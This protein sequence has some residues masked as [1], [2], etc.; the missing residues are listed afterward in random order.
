[1]RE[2]MVMS[3][4]VVWDSR[5]FT[6]VFLNGCAYV[7]LFPVIGSVFRQIV[8]D[9]ARMVL[10]M[11]LAL[12]RERVRADRHFV[13]SVFWGL[14]WHGE[15]FLVGE[16]CASGEGR[17]LGDLPVWLLRWLG[18]V[19]DLRQS[20]GVGMHGWVLGLGVVGGEGPLWL[21]FNSEICVG[22]IIGGVNWFLRFVF[23]VAYVSFFVKCERI[24]RR[25]FPEVVQAVLDVTDEDCRHR[26]GG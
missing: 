4:L 15:L 17:V 21:L 1:M 16:L 2:M 14:L 3:L 22:E 12:V 13:F 7:G 11:S 6:T 26:V 25:L 5:E 9:E 10:L 18:F 8:G 19:S 20:I 24:F 23:P